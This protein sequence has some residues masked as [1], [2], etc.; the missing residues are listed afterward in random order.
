MRIGVAQNVGWPA[1]G[2]EREPEQ[3]AQVLPQRHEQPPQDR[4]RGKVRNHAVRVGR[5]VPGEDKIENV[6]ETGGPK[7]C[8]GQIAP[9]QARRAALSV[10]C[11]GTA[12]QRKLRAKATKTKNN[13]PE[14][15]LERKAPARTSPNLRTVPREGDR[16][17]AGSCQTARTQNSAIAMSVI[18]S[19]PNARN[20]GMLA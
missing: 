13:N 17:I 18:T 6:Y 14:E 7:C 8:L 5:L 3:T 20:A 1:S 2:A 16:H 19:G 9:S 10:G 12:R 15:N 11:S 4:R